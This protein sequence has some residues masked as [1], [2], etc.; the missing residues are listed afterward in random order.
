MTNLG[1]TSWSKNGDEVPESPERLAR[2]QGRSA[3]LIP[4]RYFRL[5]ELRV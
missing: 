2:S 5:P 3:F 4:K 1:S